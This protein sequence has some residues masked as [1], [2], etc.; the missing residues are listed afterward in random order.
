MSYP[1][2]RGFEEYFGTGAVERNGLVLQSHTHS[3]GVLKELT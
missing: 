2:A 1:N 3:T